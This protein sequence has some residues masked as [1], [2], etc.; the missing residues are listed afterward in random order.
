MT[1]VARKSEHIFMKTPLLVLA[2]ALV[3]TASSAFGQGAAVIIKQRAKEAAGRPLSLPPTPVAA[4]PAGTPAPPA[5][6]APNLTK[7]LADIA[8]I[9]SRPQASQ[10]QKDKLAAD[11]AAVALGANKPSAEA[12]QALANALADAIAGKKISSAD[13]TAL[14]RSLALTLNPGNAQVDAAIQGVKDALTL[15]SVNEAAIQSVATALTG[16]TTKAK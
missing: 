15:S 14:A 16:L 1:Q 12:L 4:Q 7:L 3:C 2:L 8:I 10:E 11:L 5:V 13:Q 6:A 9:K